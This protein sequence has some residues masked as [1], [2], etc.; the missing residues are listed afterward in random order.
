MHDAPNA[1]KYINYLW[2][3]SLIQA[4]IY[5]GPD[6]QL[7]WHSFVIGCYLSGKLKNPRDIDKWSSLR[8]VNVSDTSLDCTSSVRMCQIALWVLKFEHCF[9]VAIATLH[10]FAILK[11]CPGGFEECSV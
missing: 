6:D 5:V 11:F 10:Y 7:K 9:T 1:S 3:Q 8:W 2:P 4:N